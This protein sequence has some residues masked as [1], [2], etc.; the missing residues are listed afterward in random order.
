VTPTFTPTV[1]PTPT[2]T[3]TFTPTVTPTATRTPTFTPTSTPGT[4]AHIVV[5]GGT[6]QGA[7][8]NTQFAQPLQV[9]VTDVAGQPVP[10]ALVTFTPP[11]SGPSA[12]LSTGGNATTDVDGHASVFAT[13]NGVVGGPYGVSATTGTLP[14]VTFSLT[15]LDSPS[16]QIPTLSR[17]GLL[18]FALFVFLV[19]AILLTRT[20]TRL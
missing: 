14:P 9:T 17:L 8:I 5:S 16:P 3:P 15:N 18:G 6:P 7:P 19:G 1:T 12:T 20:L 11:S 10:G 13:A 2:A 4:G